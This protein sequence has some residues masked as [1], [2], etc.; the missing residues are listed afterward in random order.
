MPDVVLPGLLPAGNLGVDE[1]PGNLDMTIYQGDFKEF[2]VEIQDEA[3]VTVNIA[4]SVPKAQIKSSYSDI[5]PITLATS[6]V[7]NNVNVFLDSAKSAALTLESYIWDLQLTDP[8]GRVKTY[9]T[10]DV[11]VIPQVTS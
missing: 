6:I 9:L 3:G 1:L 8:T 4:G 11:T 7:S 5:A 10:G 2:Y